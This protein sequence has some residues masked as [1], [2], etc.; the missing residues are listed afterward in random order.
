MLLEQIL[1]KI[2]SPSKHPYYYLSPTPYVVGNCAEEIY[3][4]LIKAKE[5]WKNF[6]YFILLISNLFLNIN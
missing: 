4:G 6:L 3:C 2:N 1:H 5:T